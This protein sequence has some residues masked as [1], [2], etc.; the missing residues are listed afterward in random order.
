MA[1]EDS[2]T[3]SQQWRAFDL[4]RSFVTSA[5]VVFLV[6]LALLAGFSTYMPAR[7]GT[8]GERCIIYDLVGGTER[9]R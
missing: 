1:A 7:E 4:R 6:L 8:K 5:S 2:A 9:P 3:G